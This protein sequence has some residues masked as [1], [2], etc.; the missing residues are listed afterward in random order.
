MITTDALVVG[1]G[2]VG[3]FQVFEL[4]LLEMRTQVVDSLPFIG[5]QCVELYAD[6]PIYDIPGLPVVTGR[7]LIERLQQQA[8]PFAPTFHLDQQVDEVTATADGRFDVTT[9]RGTRFSAKVVI[10]AAGAGSFQPR[11]LQVDGLERFRDAQV[12]YRLPAAAALAG[13][14]VLIAGHGHD[15][16]ER[17]L[18]LADRDA[19]SAPSHL[20]LMHRRDDFVADDASLARL[21]AARASGRV[22]F[23]AAQANAIDASGD[24]GDGVLT[25]LVVTRSEDGARETLPIDVIVVSLGI[26]PKLGPIADWALGLERKQVV[27]DPERFETSTSGLFAVGDIVSYA[28]KRKLIVSGFHEA[29]LAAFA[30][31]SVVFPERAQPLQYTTTSP[32]LHRLLGVAS[33]HSALE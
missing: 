30:A 31:A 21:A 1:A 16:V 10:V 28:G 26:S 14:R 25:G 6:K 12:F 23:I 27:V 7:E 4:G 3:L 32:K 8:A 29:T 5:G 2:P 15:A 13:K 18:A 9:S 19:A 22:R 20:T 11:A 24:D 33:P 17:V